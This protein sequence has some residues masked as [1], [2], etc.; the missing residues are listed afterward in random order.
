[1]TPSKTS[2]TGIICLTLSR[3]CLFKTFV[4]IFQDKKNMGSK[5]DQTSTRFGQFRVSEK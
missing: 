1:M 4:I 5:T 2:R 3:T